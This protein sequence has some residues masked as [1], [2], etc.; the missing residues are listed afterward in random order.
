M[1]IPATPANILTLDGLSKC[2]LHCNKQELG[3]VWPHPTGNVQISDGVV[4][5]NPHE[6]TFS[7]V[8][9]QNSNSEIWTMARERFLNMQQKKIPKYGIESG[10]ESLLIEVQ[11]DVDDIG[12][13]ISEICEF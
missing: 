10:G 3:T 6:I 11:V 5:L 13:N 9:F 8:A 12:E 1:K 7:P 4:K 2:R